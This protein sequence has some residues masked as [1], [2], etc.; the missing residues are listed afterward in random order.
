MPELT[1]N[2]KISL[3]IF[4]GDAV[5]FPLVERII[6]EKLK[7]EIAITLVSFDRGLSQYTN[8]EVGEQLRACMEGKRLVEAAFRELE[9]YRTEE[10]KEE[11]I[12]PAI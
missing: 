10:L 9:T 4:V 12:N 8:Q 1:H 2:E 6:K 3:E 11:K 7:A 5:L